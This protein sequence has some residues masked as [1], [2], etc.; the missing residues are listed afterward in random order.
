M[1]LDI[2]TLAFVVI[3]LTLELLNATKPLDWLEVLNTLT[4]NEQPM[5]I[6]TVNGKVEKQQPTAFANQSIE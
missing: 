1:T 3:Q 4:L 2:F 6:A 5:A